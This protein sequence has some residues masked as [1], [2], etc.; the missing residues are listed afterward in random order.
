MFF[1]FL[2]S[3]QFLLV[4]KKYALVVESRRYPVNGSE[5]HLTKSHIRN[6]I[7]ITTSGGRDEILVTN[8]EV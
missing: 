8:F 4:Q 7:I 5:D 1:R 6:V 2:F 3:V